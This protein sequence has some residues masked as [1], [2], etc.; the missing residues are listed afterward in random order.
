MD[1]TFQ[2]MA[3]LVTYHREQVAEKMASTALAR[4]TR[5][6]VDL[7]IGQYAQATICGEKSV[8]R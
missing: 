4:I 6:S 7:L 2:G 3:S 1:F 8:V 5:Y